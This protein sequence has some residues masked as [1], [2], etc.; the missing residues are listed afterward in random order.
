[1]SSCHGCSLAS[2]GE[3]RFKKAISECRLELVIDSLPTGAEV[4][5]DGELIGMTP[6]NTLTVAG[7]HRLSLNLEGYHP[8][9]KA[10]FLNKGLKSELL[11]FTLKPISEPVVGAIAP[12]PVSAGALAAPLPEPSQA[13]AWSLIGGGALAITLGA[14]SLNAAAN[15][16]E[17]LNLISD[18]KTLQTQLNDSSYQLKEGLGWAG[19]GLGVL[20]VGLGAYQL[21]F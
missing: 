18:P 19:L 5:I 15:D 17:A 6:L 10:I 11:S 7:H 4:K 14:L 16:V 20:G 8:L 1:M 21:T 13:G 2:K 3:E 9:Q 12:S